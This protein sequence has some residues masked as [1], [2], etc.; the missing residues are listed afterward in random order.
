[1]SEVRIFPGAQRL[2]G[3]PRLRNEKHEGRAVDGPIQGSFVPAYG[4]EE[5][6]T[7]GGMR[8]RTGYPPNASPRQQLAE[9]ARELLE[10]ANDLVE[11]AE[12]LNTH[13]P[14]GVPVVPAN[15]RE[16]DALCRAARTALA[17]IHD[18]LEAESA[19]RR[20][21]DP[22][23]FKQAAADLVRRTRKGE[24]PLSARE[25]VRAVLLGVA[26][27]EDEREK[28]RIRAGGT[29]GEGPRHRL[30]G[31]ANNPSAVDDLVEAVEASGAKHLAG[32][33]T[34]KQRATKGKKRGGVSAPAKLVHAAAV[35]VGAT[36]AA[37]A[38]TYQT[39]L[40]R[41]RKRR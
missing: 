7:V 25:A 2:R 33:M 20:Q 5:S 29:P 14:D 13:H 17:T 8:N 26:E 9:V 4:S 23:V 15:A 10:A 12:L 40:R 22:E 3:L 24:H 19:R 39:R 37:S 18:A 16:L 27:L 41:A 6:A 1:V 31:F 21:A 38:S 11:Q 35:K 28:A 36:D 34:A 32:R 30:Q